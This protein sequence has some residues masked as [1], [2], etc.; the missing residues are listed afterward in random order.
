MQD[1]TGAAETAT[2]AENK[3]L[4]DLFPLVAYLARGQHK[5]RVLGV[6]LQVV[7]GVPVPVECLQPFV[8]V[9]YNFTTSKKKGMEWI[10]AKMAYAASTGQVPE[11]QNSLKL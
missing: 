9:A 11:N 8:H 3:R 1:T 10:A 5:A 7:D 4:S 6:D 2:E